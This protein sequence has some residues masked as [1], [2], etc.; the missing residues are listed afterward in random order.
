MSGLI[1]PSPL[2]SEEQESK[3]I[4]MLAGLG[5]VVIVVGLAVF[6]LREKP[7]VATPPPAYVANVKISDL[8]TSAA[9]NFVGTSVNYVDG[10][11]TNTGDKTLTHAVVRNLQRFPGP[12]RAGGPASF[13][14]PSESRAVQRCG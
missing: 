14:Y 3:L 7:K 6:L 10:T 9:E 11:V 13:A 2:Q 8:K 1:D 4:P 12:G 5:V